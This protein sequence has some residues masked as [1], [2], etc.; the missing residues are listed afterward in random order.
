VLTEVS[1][2]RGLSHSSK[3]PLNEDRN[4]TDRPPGATRRG[5]AHPLGDVSICQQ[6]A[7]IT[8]TNCGAADCYTHDNKW[9]LTKSVTGNTVADGTGTVTW[10]IT[11]T[12][13][14]SSASEFSVH[15][16]LTVTNTGSAPATHWQHRHQPAEAAHRREHGGVQE[17]SVG[18]GGS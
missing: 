3:G 11:A 8:L 16:G 7:S 13:D 18:V 17:H 5:W 14:S 4:R 12:K 6:Q 10:T 15:G 2:R 1:A 9:D